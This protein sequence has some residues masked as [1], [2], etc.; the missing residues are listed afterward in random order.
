MPRV[1]LILALH[2]HQPVGNFDDVFEAS[3]RASYR[4]FLDVLG[5]YPEIPFALHTSG[6]LLEWL[7]ERRPEYVE[8]VRELAAAGRVEILGGG[9]FEPILTMIPHRDRVGQIAQFSEHLRE[10][11][12][13][14]IRGMWIPERVWEQQLVGATA[15]AGIEYTLLDDSHFGRAGLPESELFGY[16]LTEDEGRLLKVFPVSEPL[17]Y[18]IPFQEPHATY[19]YLR[20]LAEERPGA[21]IAFADDGEKFGAWPDTYDHVYTRGWLRR[22]CDMLS[23]NRDWIQVVTPSKALETT[24]P[25]GKVYL[26]DSSYREMIEWSLPSPRQVAYHKAVK[27]VAAQPAF[28]AIR[29]YVRAAGTWRNFRSKYPESDEMYVRMLSVSN[30]LASLQGKGDPD[31]IEAARQELFRGQCNCPYWHGAFGG[32]YL[33]HL[34]NAIYRHLIAADLALDDAEGIAGPRCS[35]EVGDFNLDARQEVRLESDHLIAFVRPAMGGHVYELD[36][37][38]ALTNVLA[39]LDRRPEPYHEAVAAA[40]AGDPNAA[41]LGPA[42]SERVVL[43][44]AGL[45][46]LLTYDRYPRKALIDHFFAID[47]ALDDLDGAER[48]DFVTGAYLSKAIHEPGRVTLLMERPGRVDGH[49]IHI[50]K[51]IVLESGGKALQV[52]YALDEL[53]EG[54]PLQFG[55]EINLA[56]MAGRA[57]DRY[58]TGESGES[59]GTL[60]SRLDLEPTGALGAIDEWLDLAV[61]LSWSRPASVWCLPIETVSQSEGGFEGVYQS[62]AII[63][64]WIVRGDAERR[65]EVTLTWSI[66]QAPRADAP[67]AES[68][69]HRGL[70]VHP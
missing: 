21:T 4:P 54:I 10:V 44:S 14:P 41:Q 42:V 1:R 66:D 24:L 52:H 43:K 39:T 65:W 67:V 20:R 47:A 13:Q 51:S 9:F 50:R 27:E 69:G 16:Y 70:V 40:A 63:P 3:Y 7:I 12:G 28:E 57:S 59:L 56:G 22:F 2:D 53:P 60:D 5:D 68:T 37:K 48:G 61:R 33:P 11:F 8:R 15:E 32:L 64:R 55:V 17:R 30:R 29:P 35:L 34:R 31:Y 23:G 49:A 45:D 46:R 19:E 36:V 58:F 6:P 25:M 26:P 18:L 62:S 38:H